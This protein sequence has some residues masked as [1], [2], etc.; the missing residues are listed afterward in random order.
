MYRHRV[1]PVKSEYIHLQH[2]IRALLLQDMLMA[3]LKTLSSIAFLVVN[4]TSS[5]VEPCLTCT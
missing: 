3:T 1:Q 2:S 4:S 5:V